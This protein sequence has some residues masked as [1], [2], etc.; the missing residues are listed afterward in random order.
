MMYGF[1]DM[2]EYNELAK[3]ISS[4]SAKELMENE[5]DPEMDVSL[6][7]VKVPMLE[8]DEFMPK[9]KEPTSEESDDIDAFFVA[10]GNTP[11]KKKEPEPQLGG[12][13]VAEG[14]DGNDLDPMGKDPLVKNEGLGGGLSSHAKFGLHESFDKDA[15]DE[16]PM[17]EA[18]RNA[19]TFDKVKDTF[20]SAL[21]MKFETPKTIKY[22][23]DST[24]TKNHVSDK[25]IRKIPRGW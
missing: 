19:N 14:G 4:I 22:D 24:Q 21:D 11:D 3:E 7:D 6:N 16:N 12:A 1:G 20:T 17:K 25:P 18:Q 2:D 10:A 23:M 13:T 5:I 8:A 15:T 9:K